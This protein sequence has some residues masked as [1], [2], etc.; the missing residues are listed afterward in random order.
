MEKT[1]MNSLIEDKKETQTNRDR[2]QKGSVATFNPVSC[3]FFTAYTC[4]H[5]HTHTHLHSNIYLHPVHCV[6]HLFDSQDLLFSLEAL[7]SMFAHLWCTYCRVSLRTRGH[8]IIP[9]SDFGLHCHNVRPVETLREV[10]KHTNTA[11]EHRSALL[12]PA[13]CGLCSVLLDLYGWA[14]SVYYPV[15]RPPLCVCLCAFM[16]SLDNRVDYIIL[17]YWMF[18]PS[19]HSTF[20]IEQETCGTWLPRREMCPAFCC[21]CEISAL[22]CKFSHR[23]PSCTWLSIYEHTR[24]YAHTRVR[25]RVHTHTQL[26]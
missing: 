24:T 25:T 11:W 18:F 13:W 19:P 10:S 8:K 14:N 16:L 3:M 26:L 12:W 2:L 21:F 15:L 5:M 17:V 22:A 9:H 1:C 7:S 4:V 6:F 23:V 20:Y